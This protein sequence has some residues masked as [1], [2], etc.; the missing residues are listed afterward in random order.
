MT[1]TNNNT[2][3]NKLEVA[4][5]MQLMGYLAYFNRYFIP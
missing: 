4:Q 2:K 3:E 1:D 5:L